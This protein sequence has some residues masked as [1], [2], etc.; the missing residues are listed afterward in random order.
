MDVDGDNEVQLT[1]AVFLLG[2][3]FDGV[4]LSLPSPGQGECEE[5]STESCQ[6]SNCEI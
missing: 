6:V 4:G 3:L 5:I 2:Y 1:D